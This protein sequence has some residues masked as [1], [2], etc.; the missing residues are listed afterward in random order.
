MKVDQ[1]ATRLVAQEE[2]LWSTTVSVEQHGRSTA[3]QAPAD[4]SVPLPYELNFRPA[5]EFGYDGAKNKL[6]NLNL[7][8]NRVSEVRFLIPGDAAAYE[9]GETRDDFGFTS[10]QGRLLQIS[11]L[12]DLDSRVSVGCAGAV[13][14]FL[15]RK[16]ANEFLPGDR[17]ASRA[18]PITSLEMF[19]LKDTMYGLHEFLRLLV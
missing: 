11:G 2:D 4:D 6:A 5:P 17:A 9:E 7:E 18:F 3:D 1:M 14:T 13:L 19:G 15:Q 10:R 16:R 12:I 8:M